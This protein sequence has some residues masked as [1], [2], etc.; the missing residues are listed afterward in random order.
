MIDL[1]LSPQ[2]PSCS[3]QYLAI[4]LKKLMETLFACMERSCVIFFHIY[5]DL[6][7]YMH[8]THMFKNVLLNKIVTGI[9]ES[10]QCG[11]KYVDSRP[12]DPYV[13]MKIP[14]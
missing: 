14:L 2:Y 10:T 13:L 12:S 11:Q 7:M 5:K 4:D 1:Q 6:S 9:K 3:V 8:E